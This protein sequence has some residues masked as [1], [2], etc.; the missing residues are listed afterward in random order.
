VLYVAENVTSMSRRQ[1]FTS[2]GHAK[3]RS[4]LVNLQPHSGTEVYT[5]ISRPE[6]NRERLMLLRS[7]YG[8]PM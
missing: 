7:S 2:S 3:L 5:I 8:R 1:G 6:R 4:P